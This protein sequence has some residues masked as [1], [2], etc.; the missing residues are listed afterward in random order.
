MK[1]LLTDRRTDDGQTGDQKISHTSAKTLSP[2]LDA[3]SKHYE[4][5][6]E[7]ESERLFEI[8]NPGNTFG[9]GERSMCQM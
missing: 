4:F 7:V 1:S 8:M 3:V 5:D 9:H 6:I 2:E